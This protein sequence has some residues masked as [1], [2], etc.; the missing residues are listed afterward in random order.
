MILRDPPVSAIASEP[1][2][3]NLARDLAADLGAVFVGRPEVQ[4]EQHAA[5]DGEPHVDGR[6]RIASLF[7]VDPIPEHRS[8]IKGET[9]LRAVP[10]D[11]SRIA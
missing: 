4:T 5:N 9:R 10:G 11:N 3:P 7:E 6:G 8:A 2:P 1:L